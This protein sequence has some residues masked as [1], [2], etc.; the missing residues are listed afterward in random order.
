MSETHHLDQRMIL[1]ALLRAAPQF[2]GGNGIVGFDIANAL[3]IEHPIRMSALM[4]FAHRHG[5]SASELWPWAEE[6]LGSAVRRR[7]APAQ[8][9]ERP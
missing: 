3:G 7:D 9:E 5:F 1:R 8:T 4:M 2:Q 6:M